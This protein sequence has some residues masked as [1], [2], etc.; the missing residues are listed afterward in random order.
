MLNPPLPESGD[1]Q[2]PLPTFLVDREQPPWHLLLAA[3]GWLLLGLVVQFLFS[4]LSTFI[5]GFHNGLATHN[6]WKPWVI[7]GLMAQIHQ[8]V[9]PHSCYIKWFRTAPSVRSLACPRPFGLKIVLRHL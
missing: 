2:L 8:A 9:C 4:F 1:A 3:L 5:V 6:D 7:P